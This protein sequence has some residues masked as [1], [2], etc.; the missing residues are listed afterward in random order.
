VLDYYWGM[1]RTPGGPLG[2]G[3]EESFRYASEDIKQHR[4]EQ[5]APTPPQEQNALTPPQERPQVNQPV[6]QA[7]REAAAFENNLAYNDSVEQRNT[8]QRFERSGSR[9]QQADANQTTPALESPQFENTREMAVYLWQQASNENTGRQ[10]TQEQQ[11]AKIPEEG[12]E[13]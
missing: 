1:A 4:Q 6:S 13:L 10:N 7:D 5:N 2:G 11:A 9:Q 3:M 12:Q 8:D